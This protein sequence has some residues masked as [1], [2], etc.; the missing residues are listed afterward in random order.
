VLR[1]PL[2][3][4]GSQSSWSYRSHQLLSQTSDT[5]R[6]FLS[7]LDNLRLT[8]YVHSYVLFCVLNLGIIVPVTY[9][10]F[11]ETANMRLEDIDHIFEGGGITGGVIGKNGLL[12]DRRKDI[13]RENH[14][15]PSEGVKS[16]PIISSVGGKNDSFD[17]VE[18]KTG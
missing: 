7:I 3:V 10:F 17:H 18:A 8:N 12:N 16:S 4:L 2:S 14:H 6:E 5:K 15:L 11:P 1:L 13:E 9:F